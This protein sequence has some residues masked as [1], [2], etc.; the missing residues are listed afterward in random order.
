[1][2][3]CEAFVLATES[4]IDRSDSEVLQKWRI[5]RACAHIG[6]GHLAAGRA[7]PARFRFKTQRAR[8][9]LLDFKRSYCS[10]ANADMDLWILHIAGHLIDERCGRVAG[11]CIKES[12]TVWSRIDVDD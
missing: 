10:C 2:R 1:M 6:D 8:G 7:C 3:S 11:A 4:E 12:S 5:V 9:K